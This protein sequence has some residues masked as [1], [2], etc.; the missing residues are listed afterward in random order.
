MSLMIQT[1]KDNS[2]FLNH[3]F[4]S[5]NHLLVQ[6]LNKYLVRERIQFL[7]LITLSVFL[8]NLRKQ[9]IIM[10]D[11]LAPCHY[12]ENSKQS[13]AHKRICMKNKSIQ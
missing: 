6:A 2:L 10:T 4:V 3:L 5:I 1:T 12:L 8:K 13:Y 7:S 11:N 9:D